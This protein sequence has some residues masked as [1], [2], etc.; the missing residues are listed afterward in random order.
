ME[1]CGGN[2]AVRESMRVVGMQIEVRS[3]PYDGAVGGGDVQYVSTCAAGK[4]SRF[5]LAD[6]SGHGEEADAMGQQL[7]GLI[8]KH[9]NKFDQTG[10]VQ[11]LNEGLGDITASGRF[12]TAVLASWHVPAQALLVSC[13]GHPPPLW[14]RADLD[15]WFILTPET[16][17]PAAGRAPE[18]IADLPL[19][20]IGDTQ[21]SQFI[22]LLGEGDV[23]VLY[24]D[25]YMEAIGD[26]GRQLGVDGLLQL[27]AGLPAKNV[28]TFTD[29]LHDAMVQWRHGG[30]DDDE[31][32][33]VLRATK[34]AYRRVGILERLGAALR[35][36][37]MG[38]V[39]R[40]IK[41]GGA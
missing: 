28:S 25:A 39:F 29:E 33:L 1:V 24:T 9:I 16:V 37:R 6:V 2:T 20:V 5:A 12:A 11:S 26:G 7:R 34:A 15:A 21:Y 3:T 35:V 10:L 38:R 8:R 27:A 31:T 32:L 40:S 36:C 18:G 23:V 30:A 41:S 13:A 17:G 22:A 19:G 14:Y 4:L